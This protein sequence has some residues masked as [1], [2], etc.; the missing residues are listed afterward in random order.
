MSFS[1]V[2]LG[3]T[4]FRGRAQVTE[5]DRGEDSGPEHD[6]GA[7]AKATCRPG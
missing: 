6:G 7:T 4:G 5:L 3:F 2:E 1:P